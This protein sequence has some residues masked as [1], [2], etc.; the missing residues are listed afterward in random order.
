MADRI[1]KIS[2]FP[3]L[4]AP[5]GNTFFVVDHTPAGGVANTY[6]LS[7]ATLLA[8]TAANVVIQQVA[9]SNSTPSVKKGTMFFDENYLYVA[10]ANNVL[11]RVALGSF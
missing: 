5:T 3:I 6:T 8:N 4:S 9:V 10:V 2:E 1:K 7:A 11:K